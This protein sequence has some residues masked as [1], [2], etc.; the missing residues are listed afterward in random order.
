MIYLLL[1][2]KLVCMCGKCDVAKSAKW[3]RLINSF[4]INLLLL[5]PHGLRNPIYDHL[6]LRLSDIHLHLDRSYI[7]F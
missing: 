7:H 6:D 5:H 1:M 2:R 4:P 3:Q